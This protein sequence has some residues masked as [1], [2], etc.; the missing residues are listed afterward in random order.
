M[1]IYSLEW[2]FVRTFSLI[3]AI[4]LLSYSPFSFLSTFDTFSDLCF[5][6][7]GVIVHLNVFQLSTAKSFICRYTSKKTIMSYIHFIQE[8]FL[9]NLLVVSPFWQW[10]CFSRLV[11]LVLKEFG[12]MLRALAAIQDIPNSISN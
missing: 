5:R 2:V 8:L 12:V 3:E 10:A 4:Y 7:V 11:I 6:S 1:L 9:V